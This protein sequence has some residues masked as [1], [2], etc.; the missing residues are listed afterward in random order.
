MGFI[1]GE[2]ENESQRLSKRFT[3]TPPPPPAVVRE[4]GTGA[5]RVAAGLAFLLFLPGALMH[6]QAVS[7][8][9]NAS[10]YSP[11]PIPS[12]PVATAANLLTAVILYSAARIIE[13]VHSA[14]ARR[15]P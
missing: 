3:P 5:L 7:A 9:M 6:L 1:M 12:P 2:F 11:A 13:G 4:A 15:P 8:W 10:R 14:L